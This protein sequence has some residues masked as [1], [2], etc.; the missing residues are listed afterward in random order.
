MNLPVTAACRL[1]HLR[2]PHPRLPR[3][4]RLRPHSR[5]LTYQSRLIHRQRARTEVSEVSN[6]D[7]PLEPPNSS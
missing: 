2:S 3:C 6:D 5:H 7:L 1:R 4:P